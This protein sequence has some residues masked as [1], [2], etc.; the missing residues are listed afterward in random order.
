MKINRKLVTVVV[1]VAAL[2]AGGVGLAQAIG[3][4]SETPVTGPDAA[5]AKG[6]ALEAVGGGA[7]TEVERNDENNS[8]G[9]EVEVRRDDGTRVEVRLDDRYNAIAKAVDSDTESGGDNERGEGSE[10]GR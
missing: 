8:G 9:Y 7:V 5:K 4:E 6:A 10:T 3:G 2:G 1:A